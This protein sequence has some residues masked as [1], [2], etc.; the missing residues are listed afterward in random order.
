MC[1]S[2]FFFSIFCVFGR[3]FDVCLYIFACVFCE[4]V[5]KQISTYTWTEDESRPRTQT[6]SSS[7]ADPDKGTFPRIFFSHFLLQHKAELLLRS[8]ISQRVMY[9]Y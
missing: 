1:F 4:L 7:G 8:F 2:I 3:I 9:V 5:G 6:T